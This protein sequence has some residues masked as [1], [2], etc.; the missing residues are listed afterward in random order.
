MQ[1]MIW[2]IRPVIY[3]F[4]AMPEMGNSLPGRGFSITNPPCWELGWSSRKFIHR[5]GFR[6]N[7]SDGRRYA[8]PARSRAKDFPSPS[9]PDTSHAPGPGGKGGVEPGETGFLDGAF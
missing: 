7:H 2:A 4:Q 1:G 8:W 9:A 6:H 5:C 3:P